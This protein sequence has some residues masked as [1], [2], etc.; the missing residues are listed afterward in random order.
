MQQS[1]LQGD[2][3]VPHDGFKL[4]PADIAKLP[5]KLQSTKNGME[6]TTGSILLFFGKF[7]VGCG[8]SANCIVRFI[9]EVRVCSLRFPLISK[10]VKF[11]VEDEDVSRHCGI[12]SSSF[13]SFLLAIICKTIRSF[14]LELGSQEP[15]TRFAWLKPDVSSLLSTSRSRS[16]HWTR[17]RVS[18]YRE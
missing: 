3:D 8:W 10:T 7:G 4:T 1:S 18:I 17:G 15:F 11:E 12:F 5:V 2:D 14:N 13:P 16:H 6:T 9:G